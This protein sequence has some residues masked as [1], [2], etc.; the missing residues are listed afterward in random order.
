MHKGKKLAVFW[1]AVAG[2]LMTGFAFF[3]LT[4]SVF[5]DV[6]VV[7][8]VKGAVNPKSA[9]LMVTDTPASSPY[10]SISGVTTSGTNG[11]AT[12]ETGKKVYQ[13][14]LST[15]AKTKEIQ[16]PDQVNNIYANGSS[17]YVLYGALNGKVQKYNLSLTA[18]GEP[19][20]VGHTPRAAVEKN[21]T[22][23][24][25]NRF[26]NQI[27]IINLSTMQVADTID[28]SREPFA[29][30]EANN[31]I[32]V[33]HHLQDEN[34]NGKKVACKVSVIDTANDNEIKEIKLINGSEG[35]KGI[36]ASPDGKYVYTTNILARYT[37]PTSQLD[38]G[39]INTNAIS[40]IDA[41]QDTF[42]TSVL[43]DDVDLGSGNPWG[44]QCTED[45]DKLIVASS[46]T[47]EAFVIDRTK[48]H[49]RIT[50]TDNGTYTR[51]Y[52]SLKDIPNYTNFTDGIKQ[53]IKFP[54]QAQNPR[55][56]SISSG[57]VYFG[58]Y[59]SGDISVLKLSDMSWSSISLGT[60]P[61]TDRVRR[62]EALWYDATYCYQ[63]WESCASCHP[64]ARMDSI[65]WDNLNDGLGNPKSAKSML[66]AHRTPPA[67]ATGIRETAE[68]GVRA[69]MQFIQFNTL[70]EDDMLNIDAYLMALKPEQSPYLNKDCTLSETVQLDSMNTGN[71]KNGKTL[72]EANCATCHMG[73]L[74]TDNLN[75][76][77]RMYKNY[78]WEREK[79]TTY[80]TPSLVEVWRTGPWG[81][82]GRYKT[83]Y[84][85]INASNNSKPEDERI[86]NEQDIRDIAAYVMSIGDENEIYSVEQVRVKNDKATNFSA[87]SSYNEVNVLVPGSVI[88]EIT[89]RRQWDTAKDAVAT[90]TLY[91]G[92]TVLKTE[93][94]QLPH[95]MNKRKALSL[96]M[97]N[98][99]VPDNVTKY[100]ITI[101]EANN[102]NQKLATDF[103]VNKK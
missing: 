54:S 4:T 89:F 71:A 30:T 92:N 52:K 70:S 46:G 94:K 39:W 21:G 29:M 69:G 42:L 103:V 10:L 11:Y 7:N 45:G 56:L 40:I 14:N 72:F 22:L 8:K 27:S 16:I 95:D 58:N 5:D 65:N 76:T 6:P 19:V 38:R 91:N 99:K 24:I 13:F 77:T 18:Q 33:A 15:G 17:V 67:M 66:Y 85:Y 3:A 59:I 96:N 26:S 43:L 20:N 35:V 75:H 101:T 44:I 84:D 86:S 2:S 82:D 12:D 37:Y 36:C 74:F 50:E 83:I 1:T 47:Q 81:I 68:R 100:V 31:K 25:A 55:E 80:N 87:T 9:K 49:Q 63:Q 102:P 32:Y 93:T 60:Q 23:Y 98:Y 78:G 97:N 53:R 48:L 73:P 28:V 34:A 61:E 88:T 57:N 90:F 41:Q 64:D 79:N 62:G 51:T